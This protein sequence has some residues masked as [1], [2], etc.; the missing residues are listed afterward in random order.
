MT[1]A[2]RLEQDQTPSV[3]ASALSEVETVLYRSLYLAPKQQHLAN[4]PTP[5][6]GISRAP[7]SIIG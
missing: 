6:H 1:A 4:T 7:Y 2:S 5:I 3:A